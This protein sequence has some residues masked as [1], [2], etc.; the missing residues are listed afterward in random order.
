MPW[1]EKDLFEVE[2]FEPAAEETA[3]PQRPM[4]PG[5]TN[6]LPDEA[7]ASWL[8]RY[9]EPFMVTPENLL[10]QGRDIELETGDD[11]SRRPH[12]ALIERI[13]QATGIDPMVVANLTLWSGDQSVDDLRD[14]FSA[15]RFRATS[16]VSRRKRRIAVC[17]HCLAEDTTP[18][19][20]REWIVGWATVCQNHAA[21]L[22]GNCPECGYRLRMPALSS[23][24]DFA[25]DRCP[26]C[27][28][29]LGA[30]SPR[31]AHDAAIALHRQFKAAHDSKIF[32]LPGG[33]KLPWRVALVLFDVLLGTIWIDT[34]PV[35]RR[36]LFERIEGEF[37][38]GA[39][40]PAPIGSY[41]GLLILAWIL[42]GWPDRVRTT[43]AIMQGPRP[44]RQ[45]ERWRHLDETTREMLLN[46]LL[47]IW[48]DQKPADDRGWW[49]GWIDN[50]PQT[51][52]EL[53]SHAAAD[54]FPHRRARLMALAD[55]RDGMPVELAAQAAG[56]LPNT[57]YTWLR[58][59]AADGLEAALDRQ[60][61]ML[62][63]AQAI[64]I[65]QW[66][67]EAPTNQPRWR[68][69]RVKNEV[70][71]RYG[72][73][74]SLNAARRLLRIHGPWVRRRIRSPHR[75]SRTDAR[76]HD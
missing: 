67:A 72:L 57:L 27:A 11:W 8:L 7:L 58:R 74:I 26:R 19:V 42:L 13:A 18:Y 73:E 44:R 68:S 1:S 33:E 43:I 38:R 61:G 56:I 60:R 23:R 63:Q 66:I 39:L 37:G 17:P 34:K 14:R 4:L 15:L 36:R 31:E 55:V 64:E 6:P 71:R 52:N 45:M 75:G 54:R 10:T 20:R 16:T 50:L 76:V 47:A 40:G 62:N 9:A 24:D 12:P 59:G 21:V 41:E 22:I 30:A 49:R 32:L 29:R 28:F 46:L 51:G 35:M 25:P 5:T 2:L 48:P 53:R 3:A 69:N 70:F 65:T